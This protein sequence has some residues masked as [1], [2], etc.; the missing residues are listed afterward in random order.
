M[1]LLLEIS[2]FIGAGALPPGAGTFAIRPD[3]GRAEARLQKYVRFGRDKSVFDCRFETS[4]Y[5]P[6]TPLNSVCSDRTAALAL[7]KC[8]NKS[9]SLVHQS[10]VTSGETVARLLDRNRIYDGADDEL[11]GLK[12]GSSMMNEEWI[13]ERGVGHWTSQLLDEMNSGSCYLRPILCEC[14]ASHPSDRFFC[15]YATANLTTA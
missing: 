12:E 4:F 14:V 3:F 8:L 7:G 6:S 1:N 15:C 9:T 5:F 11:D 13:D 10:S 2:E